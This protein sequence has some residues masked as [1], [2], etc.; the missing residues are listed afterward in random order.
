MRLAASTAPSRSKEKIF[1]RMAGDSGGTESG[2]ARA[3]LSKT[4]SSTKQKMLARRH[5]DKKSITSVLATHAGSGFAS[6]KSKLFEQGCKPKWFLK[7]SGIRRELRFW[8]P[9]GI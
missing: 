4:D 2:S 7:K 6:Y 5:D 3:G 8:Q 9:F 1:S